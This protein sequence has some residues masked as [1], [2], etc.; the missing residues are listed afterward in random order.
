[1]EHGFAISFSGRIASGKSQVTHELSQLLGWPRAGFSDYLRHILASQ[2]IHEPTRGQ[3]QDVGQSLVTT[4]PEKFCKD[5]LALVEFEPGGNLLLD[6]IRHVDIYRRVALLVQP[7]RPFLIHLA[8]PDDVISNRIRA[9]GTSKEELRRAEEHV[10]E[11]E[12]CQS[13]PDIA[14]HIIDTSQPPKTV[15]LECLDALKRFSVDNLTL[16]NA[17]AAL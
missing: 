15:I 2:G 9:R 14:D 11:R 7:S 17:K 5:V 10:V 13:L 4:D 8:A 6:G 12:L 1:V 16:S 3:L